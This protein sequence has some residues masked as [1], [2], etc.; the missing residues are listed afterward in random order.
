[1]VL[2]QE[3]TEKGPAAIIDINSILSKPKGKI[4]EKPPPMPMPERLRAA[5][6]MMTEV[7]KSFAQR[8]ATV[9]KKEVAQQLEANLAAGE[10]DSRR[11]PD[12]E[13][14]FDEFLRRPM[15]TALTSD[16]NLVKSLRLYSV[17][18]S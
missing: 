6:S 12:T 10:D 1:M 15:K 2:R 11:T 17:R 9:G 3:N 14:S 7:E 5:T 4:K 13:I 16:P 18:Y 8:R